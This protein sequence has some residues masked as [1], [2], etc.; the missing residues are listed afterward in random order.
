MNTMLRHEGEELVARPVA[1]GW[2][3]RYGDRATTNVYLETAVA[4][5]VGVGHDEAV[6]LA[7]RLVEETLSATASAD[8]ELPG[9][10]SS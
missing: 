2:Y 8:E 10:A 3:V 9:A 1:S 7:A 5:A 4:E 6:A